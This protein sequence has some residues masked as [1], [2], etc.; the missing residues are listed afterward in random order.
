MEPGIYFSLNQYCYCQILYAKINLKVC[1]PPPYERIL[2]YY[3]RANVDQIQRGIEQFFS[4]EKLFRNI[5]VFKMISLFNR[6]F[7][8]ILSN[9]IPHEAII[10]DDKVPP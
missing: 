2:W 8:N 6:I 7:K 3:Q 5:I 1:Y 4:L 9:Y 10:C